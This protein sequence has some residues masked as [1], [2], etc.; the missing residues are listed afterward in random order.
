MKTITFICETITPMFLSGADGQTPELRP[1]SIKGALRFWWR[2]MNGGDW[3][4][5]KKREDEIFGS[6]EKKSKLLIA[7]KHKPFKTSDEDLEGRKIEVDGKDFKIDILGYL[8]YG[9]YDNKTKTNNRHYIKTNEKFTV[10]LSTN[11]SDELIKQVIASFFCVSYFGGIGAKSRNGFGRFYVES[12]EIDKVKQEIPTL[13]E[14]FA[15]CFKKPE[16]SFTTFSEKSLMFETINKEY[17]DYKTVLGSLGEIYR[18]V[19]LGLEAKHIYNKRQFIAS[20]IVIE[21]EGQ[22]SLLD[23]HSKPYFLSVI[24][25]NGNKYQGV[26]LFLP[27]EYCAEIEISSFQ[28]NNTFSDKSISDLQAEFISVTDE[29]NTALK[30]DYPDILDQFK[31]TDIL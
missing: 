2:A 20:P 28:S 16:T 1:P 22:Q 23:R 25:S 11:L 8:L 27:Y 15:K 26:I 7:T 14:L 13:R 6:T 18:T 10:E 30:T 21:G 17:G 9:I 29:F 19:K 24:K 31:P 12:F 4:T 5:L 3:K